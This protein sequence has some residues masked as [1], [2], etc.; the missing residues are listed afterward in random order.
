MNSNRPSQKTPRERLVHEDE[1]DR[2]LELP[3]YLEMVFRH[4]D[5]N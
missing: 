5:F 1:F 3:E 2:I 4:L